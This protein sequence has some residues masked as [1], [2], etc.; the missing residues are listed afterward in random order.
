MK[1]LIIFFILLL[2]PSYALDY[3]LYCSDLAPSKSLSG[4]LMSTTGVNFLARQIAQ[5]EIAKALKKETGSKFDVKIGTFFAANITQGEF[6]KFSAISKNYSHDN[7]SAQKLTLETIC[8]Y[9]KISYK[10]DKLNY[11]TEMVLKFSAENNQD[12]LSKMLNKEI[13]IVNNKLVFD[14]KI[15]AFGIKTKLS[16]RA[17]VDIKDNKIELCNIELNNKTLNASK[18][19]SLLN[20]T[21]FKVNLDKST[22]AQVKLDD[23]KIKN[24]LVYLEGYVLVPK[25]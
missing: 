20:L 13:K 3:G 18:Y 19:L 1:K 6:S 8:P 16:L 9:N 12:N 24:S 10:N 2:L 25:S 22:K 17:G 5:K 14:Y 21:N 15:S 23:V 7:F 4:A 11:D